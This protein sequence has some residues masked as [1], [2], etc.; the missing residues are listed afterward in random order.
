MRKRLY[1][2]DIYIRIAKKKWV[3]NQLN[4]K[5]MRNEQALQKI[6]EYLSVIDAKLSSLNPRMS[7]LE[8]RMSDFEIKMKLLESRMDVFEKNADMNFH[9]VNKKLDYLSTQADHLD[10]ALGDKGKPKN[11]ETLNGHGSHN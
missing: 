9:A 4:K 6:L 11:L 2:S 10:T 3:R 1:F 8:T 5:I 7:N